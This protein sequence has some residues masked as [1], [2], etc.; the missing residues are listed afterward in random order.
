MATPRKDA[1]AQDRRPRPRTLRDDFAQDIEALV[2]RLET[3]TWPSIRWQDDPVGF[4]TDVLG[5]ALLP[6]QRE[7]LEA[8]RD[9]QQV[10]VRSGHKIGKTICAV[11]LALW[12]Y[13]TRPDARVV[14]TATTAAQ[15]DKV[16][17]REL[18]RRHRL[19]RV[20]IDG[21][22][23]EL[24][25]TGLKAID[26][27]EIV[28]FTAK[29]TEAVAG[30]SGADLLYIIDEAS[31]LDQT[32]YEAI[33]GNL[34]SGSGRLLMISNPT[35]SEGPFF[36]VFH[37]RKSGW[38]LL[39]YS[40]EAI[41]IATRGREIP[42]MASITRIEQWKS[43]YGEES[44]FY[45]VRCLGEFILNEMGKAI[46]LDLILAA[47]DRHE[48]LPD[49]NGT[50]TIGLDPAG[51]GTSGDETCFAIVRG[52]KM[53]GLYSFHGLSE[54]AIIEHL[55][56]FVRTYRRGDEIPQVILDIE[57]PIGSSLSYRLNPMA[58]D[59]V[60]RRPY[61]GFRVFGVKASAAARRQPLIY[62]RI[63]EELFANLQNWLRT[64]GIT[65]DV[66]LEVE[67]HT[68][69]WE[70]LT[71]G[72]LKLMSKDDIRAKIGRSPDRADALALAVWSP[73]PWLEVVAAG[74]DREGGFTRRPTV[75]D[76]A[77]ARRDAFDPYA[78]AEAAI[79]GPRR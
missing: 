41:A 40:S 13:C 7:I 2:K 70:T 63:R 25:R 15:I 68:P 1:V 18:R 77:Y 21:T 12:W 56:G 71:K 10:A 36:E 22:L 65:K 3:I 59:L 42:G 31:S 50:L 67:L 28:G 11:V 6:H 45:R 23:G 9:H 76:D 48:D 55:T 51:P 69:T 78:F 20:P 27:R 46:S 4:A 57:G 49:D 73:A 37:H 52:A 72:T 19:A 60:A 74:A 17:F 14:A 75:V 66:R 24:A 58:E 47:Q 39:H 34:A 38:H 8:V 61:E 54:D 30:V 35:R 64:G 33:Q 43:D 32:I 26:F 79:R 5:L 29:E 44:V 62:D 16:F 53:L